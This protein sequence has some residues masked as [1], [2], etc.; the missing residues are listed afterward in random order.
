MEKD[1]C[2]W[3]SVIPLWCMDIWDLAG[4]QQY[5][6]IW[7]T[8]PKIPLYKINFSIGKNLL[9]STGILEEVEIGWEKLTA[10]PTSHR[11]DLCCLALMLRICTT[12]DQKKGNE[13]GRWLGQKWVMVWTWNRYYKRVGWQVLIWSLSNL[14]ILGEAMRQS[15]LFILVECQC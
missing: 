6:R 8:S 9:I 5:L 13:K 12:E 10:I 14:H 4:L 7:E 11:Y 2:S 15:S 1:M 3:N